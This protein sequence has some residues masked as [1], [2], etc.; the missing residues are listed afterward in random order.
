M[1]KFTVALAGNPNTGKSSVFNA[2]T[3]SHQHVGNW[4]GKT[5]E[6][7]EGKFQG[8]G[9]E[10]T[11]VDLPGTYSLTAFSPEEVIAR[12]FI[13][14]QKPDVVVIILDSANLERNLYLAVQVLELG[15]RGI[16]VLNMMDIADSYNIKIDKEQL[17]K[18][19]GVPVVTTIASKGVGISD[20]IDCIINI[21]KEVEP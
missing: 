11:V 5:I 8:N 18:L 20:L 4:P 10:I 19:I 13:I 1:K 14:N 17:S 6:K 7:K 3:G 2:L 9:Y 12:D 21:A 15:V 16:I